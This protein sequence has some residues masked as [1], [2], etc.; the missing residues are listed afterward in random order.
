MR[1]LGQRTKLITPSTIV[2][3][4]S[5]TGEVEAKVG[6][7]ASDEGRNQETAGA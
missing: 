7:I 2:T 1:P 6:E 4:S 5:I 3:C